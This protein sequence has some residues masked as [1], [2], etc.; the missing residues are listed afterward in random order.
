MGRLVIFLIIGAIALMISLIKSA[1]GR[2]TG[3]EELRAA[4]V[5]TEAAKVMD[6]TA[7][8]LEWMDR[9]WQESKTKARDPEPD[10]Q[11]D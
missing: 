1:A 9:Q 10:S 3:N 6:K 11:R 5:K 4:T 2:V 7:R 8:G